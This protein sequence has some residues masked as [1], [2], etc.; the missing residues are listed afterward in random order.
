M[1]TR[2]YAWW[3]G[4][5]PNGAG[6]GDAHGGGAGGQ[7]KPVAAWPAARLAAA[8]RLFGE[9]STFPAAEKIIAHQ[10]QPLAMDAT[11]NLL[12][13]AAGIGTAA[14]FIAQNAGA[15]VTGLEVDPAQVEQANRFAEI[16]GLGE[17]V[18]VQEG[19]L[20]NCDIKPGTQDMIYGRE[21]L[22]GLVDKDKTCREIWSLL[23]PGGQVLLLDFMAKKADAAKGD[24]AAWGQFEK[25]K[26]QLST[27]EQIKQSLT[28]SFLDVQLAEDISKDFCGQILRGLADVARNLK[29]DSI[30]KDERPWILWEVEM[31]ARRADML[32][33][34][35]IGF[36]RIHASKAE[37]DTA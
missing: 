15:Q 23:R 21:T 11:T 13:M 1:F 33:A 20:G 26:P 18:T 2:L 8:Q 4:T 16:A 17:K 28:A 14:R 37:D 7:G 29:Q 12:D 10:I 32:Q 36:Y 35:H 6:T 27:V 5:D 34:G 31:W 9:G 19:G 3:E 25:M 24:A 22:L 30:P